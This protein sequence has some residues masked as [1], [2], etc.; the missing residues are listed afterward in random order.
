MKSAPSISFTATTDPAVNGVSSGI[1]HYDVY[2]DNV[3]VN[4]TALVGAGPFTWTDNASQSLNPASGSNLYSLHGA[5]GRRRRQPDLLGQS[6][7]HAGRRSPT[8]AIGGVARR[9]RERPVALGDCVRHGRFGCRLGP[10]R[11]P[12]LTIGRRTRPSGHLGPRRSP[13]RSNGPPVSPTVG[14]RSAALA[15]DVAGNTTL[16]AC[17]QR[18]RRQHGPEHAREAARSS[19]HARGGADDHRRP[20]DRC[21]HHVRLRHRSLRRVPRRH[22][23]ADQRHRDP[24]GRPLHLERY[25]WLVQLPGRDAGTYTYTVVAVDNAG[26]ASAGSPGLSIVLDPQSVSAPTS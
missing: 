17:H 2:R 12:A 5:R 1:N 23:D 25:D 16:V 14:T 11:L 3:K 4:K 21:G 7:D 26:N 18:A 6:R 13:A 22:P 20:D 15:S 8:V 19:A 24:G 9:F 10:V